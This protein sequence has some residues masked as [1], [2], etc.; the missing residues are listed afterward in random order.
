M[1]QILFILLIFTNISLAQNFNWITP[2]TT[3]LKLY[4]VE[5]GIYRLNRTDFI[6]AGINTS[7]IDPRT[8]K[9]YYKG[10]EI[11]IYFFGQDNGVFDDT[12]YLDFYGQRNYGG[13]TVTYKEQN[14][15]NV[16]DYTTNE[17]YNLYS[18]TSVYW[19]GWDGANGL[20]YTDYNFSSSSTYTQNFFYSTVHFE[21]D[22]IYSLG[23]KRSSNDYRNFNNEKVSGEG[24]YWREMNRGNSVSDTFRIPFL[25]PGSQPCSLK[26]FAY[27]NSYVDSIFNEHRLIVRVNGS[28]VDTLKTDNYKRIDTTII[29]SSSLLSASSLNQVSFTYTGAGTYVG[30]ML[31]DN[32]EISYPKKFDFDNSRIMF[33]TNSSDTSGVKYKVSG[34]NSA[35][36]PS[37]YDVKNN[38]RITGISSSSDTLIFTGKL[39]GK[40]EVNNNN[41]T[42]KPFRIKQRSVPN[43]VT[44]S[45]G[46]DYLI[47]YNKILESSAEQLRQHRAVKD[48]YRSVKFEIEDIYDVF[49]YG[50]ENPLA[51]RLFVKNIYD[52]WP[53]P[54]LKY[55]CLFGRGSLDPKKN[56]QSSVYFNNLVPVY[57]NPISDGYFVNFNIGAFTY[58]HQISVGRIPAY[59]NPEGN[60]M[61]TNIIQ[62]ENQSSTPEKWFKNFVFITGGMTI[63]EQI[64]FA[65][66][67]NYFINSYIKP[68]PNSG[69]P[70]RVFRNDSA[71]G[72][73]FNYQDSIKNA[74]NSGSTITNYIGHAA[75]TT[76]DNGLDDPSVLSNQYRM[77]VIFSMTCFT[78]KN[79][80][81]EYRSFGEK[82]VYMSGK[83]AVGFVGSTGWSF[84][85]SGNRF[86]EQMIKSF[87]K[88]TLRRIGDVV[89]YASRVLSYDS[90]DFA[91]RN[92]VN[93]YGMLGDPAVKL[94]M[95]TY[96][97]FGIGLT[98]YKFS[99]DFP[100]IREPVKLTVY[101][102][103]MGIFS[104]S[105][106]I[107][108]TILRNG[109]QYRDKD[110]V[111]KS[112]GLTD[113]VSYNFVLDSAG[114]YSIRVKLDPNNWN[115][116]EI[117]T[118]NEILI[119]IVL[120][121]LSFIPLKPLDNQAISADS[122]EI[123]GINPNV[124]PRSNQIKLILQIDSTRNFNSPF[125]RTYFVSNPSGLTT[126]FRIPFAAKD[127]NIVYFFR[128][129]SI[130]NSDTT[131]W[132]EYRRFVYRNSVNEAFQKGTI[133]NQQVSIVKKFVS[134][135]NNAD[136]VNAGGNQD[137]MTIAY[138]NGNVVAQSWGN[139]LTELTSLTVGNSVKNLIDSAY[140]GGLIV[141]KL[142]KTN[143]RILEMQ[144]FRFSTNAASDSA[145][146][147]LNTF[148]DRHILVILK[149][150]PYNTNFG[151]NSSLRSKIKLFGSTAVDSVNLQNFSTWSL[152][153]Y[154]QFPNAVKS[155]KFSPVYSP[156]TSSMEPLFLHDS[157]YVYHTLMPAQSYGYFKWSPL[158]PQY[159][160]MFFDVYRINRSNQTVLLY[161]NLTNSAFTGLDTLSTTVYPGLRLVTRMYIDSLNGINPPVLKSIMYFYT[162]SPEIIADN[163]S[164]VKSDS[165]FNDGDTVNIS[166]NYGN[167][168]YTDATGFLNKWYASSPSGL[169]LMRAD[170]VNINLKTDSVTKSSVRLPTLGLRNPV[171]K[172][173][174]IS[175]YFE[176]S[177][178]NGQNEFFTY[179]NT[180]VTRIIV[181]GDT[182]KPVVDITYDGINAV[183][184]E[185][186]STNPNIVLKFYDNSKIFI[187]DTSN[188]RVQL[189]DVN[190]WYY[191]NGVKNPLIDLQFPD[192]KYLQAVLYF[193]PQLSDGEHK[194]RYVSFDR[195]NNYA[196]T[197]IHYLSVNPDLKIIDL[198]NFPNPM[199]T[200]TSFLINLS[201]N[202][203]PSNSRI[204]IYTVAGR[205]IKT[206][207]SPLNIGFNQISWDGRDDDGDYI[208]NGVYLYKLIIEGN[209]KKETSLQKLVVLK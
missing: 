172:S 7:S 8:V 20:R 59:T 169:R 142:N 205:L 183:S 89:R 207:E 30:V 61:V 165:V 99:N 43:L 19:V 180:A 138:Y 125:Q 27:P 115:T 65:N 201:G 202:M 177:L 46:A 63:Q 174:T 126:K 10:S 62:Y 9:V 54:R 146:A 190:V 97:E 141:F 196:D 42:K 119:P 74:I 87:S 159:S 114:N 93:C 60:A 133:V 38:L 39:N 41:I 68:S 32:F 82:F 49:G 111:I 130:V 91:T 72:V 136:L 100:S 209:G 147:Y 56:S 139:N 186:I 83:G 88:D 137:S 163:Y 13:N 155:E 58:Y 75:S 16:A 101:P 178:I 164:F 167:Y 34:Y 152:I 182:A 181:S 161:K 14:G 94:L 143:S 98:D 110:T 124:D 31:F 112:F 144:R 79:A 176:T 208:A 134:Q 95:P 45:Q 173:D 132:S 35:Q 135:Y 106:K 121:N 28:I 55:L 118:N 2:N 67:S 50:F 140:W 104:D 15:T 198:K 81:A 195:N 73:T 76:W 70:V 33:S 22:L 52:T 171:K 192:E 105:M 187:K 193:R 102:F 96:P 158:I 40:F 29:F 149:A 128:M 64:Q 37:V 129:N 184:G 23:E 17:F 166:V 109:T 4:V 170:T 160:N 78:G 194:F 25:A 131:G 175:I 47:V 127:S 44:N 116:K 80:E 151:M 122:V 197:V 77:P 85:Y 21:R 71:G 150:I 154:S 204:K 157:A 26:V 200:E 48:G 36:S 11:P 203:P 1:K 113:T 123:L 90:L 107:S 199:T 86:N 179:N 53:Q 51:V 188:I 145:L 117:K 191:I 6:S 185:Y 120:K 57:G 148:D 3:Y 162:P 92:T 24:W 168:G 12:D 153:S 69:F 103:N 5:D 156:S 66:Q 18:D 189:D 84:S 206:I 108:F